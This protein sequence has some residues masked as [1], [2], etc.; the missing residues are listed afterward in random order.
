MGLRGHSFWRINIP[1]TL[2]QIRIFV[3]FIVVILGIGPEN[4]AATI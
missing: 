3:S 2:I 1:A 4:F